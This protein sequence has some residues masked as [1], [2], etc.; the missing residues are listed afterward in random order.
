[1]SFTFPWKA[2]P[3]IPARIQAYLGHVDDCL[4][5]FSD[6]VRRYLD[7]G[8]CPEVEEL[9]HRSHHAESSADDLRREIE[10]TLFERELLPESRGDLL[11]L[12]ES[13]DHVPGA[14]QGVLNILF[15]E[16]PTFPGFLREDFLELLKIN[17][18]AYAY[19]R[20][21]V[22]S[23]MENPS[24]TL[25]LTRQVDDLESG[26]DQLQQQALR[27]LFDSDLE[28]A[29]KLQ[30]KDLIRTVGAISDRCEHSADLINII[31]IK[32]RI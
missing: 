21:A 8:F 2:S 6:A 4:E 27:R 9:R 11:S 14:T 20:E 1:M 29:L 10:K 17:T 32:R 7:C 30:I 3:N 24:K 15:L 16:R 22:L 23:L 26:S 28:L 18:Q 5:G 19:I 13:L 31:A 25:E 12:L